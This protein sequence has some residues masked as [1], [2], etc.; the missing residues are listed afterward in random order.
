[1]NFLKNI[2]I[3]NIQLNKAVGSCC[4]ASQ[5]DGCVEG[6]HEAAC[7]SPAEWV[8]NGVCSDVCGKFLKYN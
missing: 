2:F 4:G 1:L 6:V 7:P 5:T 3:S 8:E